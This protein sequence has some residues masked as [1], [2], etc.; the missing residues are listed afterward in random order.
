[1]PLFHKSS[2]LLHTFHSYYIAV[3]HYNLYHGMMPIKAKSVQVR[4]S[5]KYNFMTTDNLLNKQSQEEHLDAN[6]YFIALLC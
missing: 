3:S 6:M 2:H 5:S 4:Q 1:M